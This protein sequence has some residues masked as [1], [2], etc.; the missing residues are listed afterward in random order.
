MAAVRY[1]EFPGRTCSS[2]RSWRFSAACVAADLVKS[3]RL[4]KYRA[5]Y[6]LPKVLCFLVFCAPLLP[7]AQVPVVHKEGLVHGFLV[8]RTLQGETVA[9]GDLLQNARGDQVTS[10]VIFHFKDGSI[11]DETAVFSQGRYFRLLSDHLIQKGPA[12]EHP[13]DVTVNRSTGEVNVRYTEAGHEKT[14]TEH[15]QLPPD[16]ANG[17]VLTLLKNLRPDTP[18]MTVGFVA[19]TP[20]PRLVKLIIRPQG[21][22]SFSTGD[23]RRKARHYVVRVDIG[24]LTGAFAELLGKQPPDTHVWILE[25]EAPAFLKSE[26]PLTFGGP[27]WRIELVSPVWPKAPTAANKEKK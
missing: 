20:K 4:S 6:V 19:T 10:R 3:R 9:D 16:L 15:L 13:V 24:G 23:T 5:L 7:A 27:I 1:R 18:E 17:L 21:E 2:N 22:E 14:E 25:G 11:Y 26:G 12:F 8:L